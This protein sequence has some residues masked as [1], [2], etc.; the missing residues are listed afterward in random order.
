[1]IG[2]QYFDSLKD[3]IFKNKHEIL[4][5]MVNPSLGDRLGQFVK[6]AYSGTG[7]GLGHFIEPTLVSYGTGIC[8]KAQERE[9]KDYFFQYQGV[10]G[11]VKSLGNPLYQFSDAVF[12][13]TG[14][15]Q[16]VLT[17]ISVPDEHEIFQERSDQ[18]R[19]YN[20]AVLA[21]L[22][23]AIGLVREGS[24]LAVNYQSITQKRKRRTSTS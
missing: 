8:R 2:S 14:L 9:G 15:V 12:S 17:Q 22:L 23:V 1:M 19:A 13:R 10:K 3:E 21:P 7:K 11:S 16:H 6:S 18:R 24:L 20:I 5:S 4:F